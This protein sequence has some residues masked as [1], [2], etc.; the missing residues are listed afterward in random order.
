MSRI[1]SM[2]KG[3][4][5]AQVTCFDGKSFEEAY[6]A[7]VE[8]VEKNSEPEGIV[9]WEP[10]EYWSWNNILEHIEDEASGIM[11]IVERSLGLVKTG[12]I[13]AAIQG[14]LDSDFNT[15]D[16][17]AMLERGAQLEEEKSSED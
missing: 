16:L 10:L 14:D 3:L 17:Q 13:D 5:T 1:E 6:E 2:V 7:I 4:A 9:P 15:L 12:L 11:R 8:A